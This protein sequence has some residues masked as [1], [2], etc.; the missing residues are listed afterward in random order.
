MNKLTRTIANRTFTYNLFNRVLKQKFQIKT[1]FNQNKYFQSDFLNKLQKYNEKYNEK[2]QTIQ[3]AQQYQP[4]EF[5]SGTEQIIRRR[6]QQAKYIAIQKKKDQQLQVFIEAYSDTIIELTLYMEHTCYQCQLIES[7][8]N[9]YGVSFKK[10]MNMIYL[11]RLK[12]SFPQLKTKNFP[13]LKVNLSLEQPKFFSGVKDIEK[14]L[15]DQMFIDQQKH[16]SNTVWGEQGVQFAEKQVLKTLD[17]LFLNPILTAELLYK[18]NPESYTQGIIQYIL[19]KAIGKL[20]GQILMKIVKN[21]PQI[22]KHKEEYRA[23]K[24]KF[25]QQMKEWDKMIGENDFMGDNSQTK[26]I[27]QCYQY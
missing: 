14:Y 22:L 5:L 24:D 15:I 10:I 25:I 20:F 4:S 2:T 21:I 7:I 11:E 17:T 19:L 26:L 9:F 18:T 16:K 8:L 12:F 27:F 13:V 6:R 23:A 1:I 3:Q